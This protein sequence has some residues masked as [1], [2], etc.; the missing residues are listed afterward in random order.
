MLWEKGSGGEG[1]VWKRANSSWISRRRRRSV[2]E[3]RDHKRP[4]SILTQH[5][6][7][8]HTQNPALNPALTPRPR[9]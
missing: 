7:P 9:G 4:A 5:T 3:D 1:S 2:M 6:G 8:H